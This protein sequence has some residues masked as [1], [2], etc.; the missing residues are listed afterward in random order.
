M[1]WLRYRNTA[2]LTI[3]RMAVDRAVREIREEEVREEGPGSDVPGGD[4]AEIDNK[5]RDLFEEFLD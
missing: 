1:L 5:L 3:V 4:A 2:M